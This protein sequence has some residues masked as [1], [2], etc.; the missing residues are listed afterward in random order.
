MF[1]E[2]PPD[3]RNKDS[4]LR[5]YN[6]SVEIGNRNAQAMHRYA[7]EH[8]CSMYEAHEALRD[9]LDMKLS[10]PVKHMSK[11]ELSEYVKLMYT[12]EEVLQEYKDFI[13]DIKLKKELY[14]K[15]IDDEIAKGDLSEYAKAR[16]SHYDFIP[17][18]YSVLPP[19]IPKLDFLK[20]FK[21]FVL[22][23]NEEFLPDY[24]RIFVYRQCNCN[25]PAFISYIMFILTYTQ[26]QTVNWKLYN[27]SDPLCMQKL[28]D[29]FKV[30]GF[31]EKYETV[32]SIYNCKR[33]PKYDD[34]FNHAFK[35]IRGC[36]YY[37]ET[38]P[39][40]G[41]IQGKLGKEEM[42]SQKEK[43]SYLEQLNYTPEEAYKDYRD[44]IR[45]LK[46]EKEIFL[47]CIDEEI[48]KGSE[49]I[50][51]KEHVEYYY[52]P[53]HSSFFPLTMTKLD[54]LSV[55]KKFILNNDEEVLPDYVRAKSYLQNECKL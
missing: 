54:F 44:Q 37:E 29:I 40:S 14:L 47:K 48:A 50:Y 34:Y 4:L 20:A 5:A 21:E 24:L 30:I 12:P 3:L 11:D 27:S 43:K 41:L 8:N 18:G 19:T 53:F 33:I 52:K 31:R 26:S 10:V 32:Q 2:L 55:F 23:N 17:P 45:N 49:S 15:C 39:V 28:D 7:E 16:M 42:M 6:A 51:A 25:L 22:I 46:L 35:L 1:K 9:S 36:W 38:D 13:R